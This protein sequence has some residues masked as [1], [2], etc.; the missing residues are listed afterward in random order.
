MLKQNPGR[1][2]VFEELIHATQYR[3]GE[4][5]GS[6]VSRLNCEIKA[7]KK[8]LRNNKAYKLTE[9]EVEQTKIALQQYESELKAYMKK[10]A[11]DMFKVL[12]VFKI[13]DMLSVTLDGKCEMLKN[14]TKLYDKSGRTYE[15]V[16]VAMTRYNDP[17]DIAKSTTVLLKACDI[18][19]GSELFIA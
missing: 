15:V 18:K 2:S 14:G 12:D 19:T 5:D 17:S 8:L 6:Y 9:A 7:Q 3:N 4:N 11:T 13:G 16:S 1:A 10:E